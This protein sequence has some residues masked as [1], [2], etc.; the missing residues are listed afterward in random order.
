[1]FERRLAARLALVVLVLVVGLL[2][3][4]LLSTSRGALFAVPLVAMF[5]L[6]HWKYFGMRRMAVSV[7]V[8]VVLAVVGSQVLTGQPHA[9]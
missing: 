8:F 1:M 5:L 9:E 3:A 2:V 7:V 4:S 6:L